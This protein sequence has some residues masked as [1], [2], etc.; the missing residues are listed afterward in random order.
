MPDYF[1]D[2]FVRFESLDHL[3]TLMKKKSFEGGGGSVRGIRQSEIKGGNA[4]NIAYALGIFG[5]NVGLTA[6]A[7][8]LPEQMLVSTF[9]KLPNVDLDIICGKAGYT[10][11]F[12]FREHNRHVNVMV[13]DVG[14][15]L[16]FDGSSISS[17]SLDSIKNSS[18]VTIVNWAANSKGN[19]LCERIFG[20]AKKYGAKTFFDPADVS[21]QRDLLPELKSKVFDNGFIDFVSLNEN[22]ARIISKVL[23]SHTLPLSYSEPELIETARILSRG[24]DS[25]IDLHTQSVTI[26][27]NGGEAIS[28]KCHTVEQK[29]V[30]GAGDVWAAANLASYLGGLE[31]EDRLRFANAAAGLYVSRESAMTPSLKE[32]YDFM[33]TNQVTVAL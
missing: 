9:S 23:F 16:N 11:A 8:S 31:D 26:S 10:I 3:V 33:N 32:V 17:K 7:D 14:D 20:L 6:V 29:T 21:G 24:T 13:S 18:I 5:V 15:L 12:E 2:R 22:E 25:I 30:T 4:V 1:V 19:Q 28:R 27:A